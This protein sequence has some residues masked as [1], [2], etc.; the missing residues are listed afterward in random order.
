MKL[1]LMALIGLLAIS[2]SA[3]AIAQAASGDADAVR[4]TMTKE[5]AAWEKYDARAVA[6]LYT[7]LQYP[8]TFGHLLLESPPLWIGDNQLLKDVEKAKVLP[9]KIYVGM[10]TNEDPADPK[11]S[12]DVVKQVQELEAE[13]RK[14]GLGPARLKVVVDEGG[15]HNEANWSRRLPEAMLF[16]YGQ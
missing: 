1:S 8:G 15:Q 6:A 5:I 7:A 10:G 12:A 13:L 14:K 2:V 4:A 16:L 9:G 3:N 11:L